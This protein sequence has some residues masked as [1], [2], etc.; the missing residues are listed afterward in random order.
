MNDPY[1]ILG[2]SKSASQ[3]EIKSA[4][5]KLAKKY[6]PDLNQNDK[7]IEQKFKDITI[8]YDLVSDPDKR[9][10][11]DKG[12][13]DAQGHERGF[14]SGGRNAGDFD[15]RSHRASG[16]GGI[17][18][19]D[20]FAEFFGRNKGGQRGFHPFEQEQPAPR[21]T[22]YTV[23]VP[24]TEA[25]LGAKRRVTLDQSKVIDITIPA[26]TVDGDKL[27]LRGVGKSGAAVIEIKVQPHPYFKL[28]GRNLRLDVP[29]SLPEAVLGAQIHVPTLTGSVAMKIPKGTDTDSVLR[30]KGKG[31][32]AG[33]HAPEGDLLL[34]IKIML[35][36]SGAALEALEK[37]GQKNAYDPRKKMLWHK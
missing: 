12:E 11:Y 17:N 6:H 7:A 27:R 10:R 22:A 5:R 34:T 28:D 16:H 30:L 31:L 9:A 24:F 23:T 32:P 4:Y 37:W 2:V 29:I 1:K 35:P 19:E 13:I 3:A 26:G 21:D 36:P 20:L 25:A 18:V 8:A 33:P 14:H 15:F